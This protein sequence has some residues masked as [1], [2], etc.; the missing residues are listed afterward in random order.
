M[1][2]LFTVTG[3]TASLALAVV[4]STH[5]VRSAR[6][7]ENSDGPAAEDPVLEARLKQ[8]QT[9]VARPGDTLEYLG[10][11][12][13]GHES[14]WRKIQ[15]MNPGLASLGPREKL[16]P[17][18]SLKY[19]APAVGDNYVVV[20]GDWLVR[21]AAWKYGDTGRWEEL[22]RLNAQKIQNPNIIHPG[23]R[24]VL[25]SDGRVENRSTGET[26]MEGVKPETAMTS[27][28]S[29]TAVAAANA[30]GPQL[31]TTGSTPANPTFQN[32]SASAPIGRLPASAR[33]EEGPFWNSTWFMTGFGSGCI[34]LLFL[35][36]AWWMASRRSKLIP[37]E[38]AVKTGS[39][40]DSHF[41]P[42]APEYEDAPEPPRGTLGEFKKR[43]YA[44]PVFDRSLVR[45]DEGDVKKPLGY[46][47]LFGGVFRKYLKRRTK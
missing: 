26:L 4:L 20:S 14:W 9:Y 3:I 39:S 28:S 29:E 45:Y 42:A 37:A 17:G 38:V 12:L 36:L 16:K 18:L 27:P 46:D 10:K 22:F 44:Y 47:A 41:E 32:S 30:P 7:G 34:L 23:D 5:S 2:S 13:Y 15:A 31:Q 6:A 43:P 24:L 1:K 25:Q 11:L 40:V 8:H 33:E 21:I 19:P 35:P